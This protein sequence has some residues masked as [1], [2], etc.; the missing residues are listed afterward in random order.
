MSCLVI[1]VWD[2][3]S[4]NMRSVRLRI[5]SA[6]ASSR[7][8]LLGSVLFRRWLILGEM[9]VNKER[10]KKPDQFCSVLDD[11]PCCWLL[12]RTCSQSLFPAVEGKKDQTE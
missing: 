12:Q 10:V 9:D 3:M 8:T 2:R 5:W 4:W 1:G 7:P 11:E 6:M